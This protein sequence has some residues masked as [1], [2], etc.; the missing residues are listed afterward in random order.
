MW[1]ASWLQGLQA[2]SRRTRRDRGR[3]LKRHQRP[4][5]RIPMPRLLLERLEE[6]CLLSY[7]IT[8]LGT[9][10]GGDYSTAAGIND[11]GQVVGYSSAIGGYHAFLWDAV[12]GMQD[13]GTLGGSSSAQGI[14]DSGQVVG[15]GTYHAFLW[16]ATNGMQ[17]L[18]TLPAGRF[19]MAVG[20]NDS[21][22]VVGESAADPLYGPIHAFLWDAVNGMQD[23]GTLPGG[24]DSRAFSINNSGQV[25]GRSDTASGQSHACL[26]V[27]VS[28]AVTAPASTVHLT[29]SAPQAV[30]PAD[31]TFTA[32]DAGVHTFSDTGLGETTVVT[33]G[34]QTV[35]ATDTA[36]DTIT[37]SAAVTVNSSAPAP[38]GPLRANPD[39]A[40]VDRL[41][42]EFFRPR[43]NDPGLG[44]MQSWGLGW[45][46]GADPLP[47]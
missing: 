27:P 39:V 28:F 20:I 38:R 42:A 36:D 14:N 21:G 40:P 46:D 30:L 32:A 1:L 6:R 25:V 37:G 41:F 5:R 16:D 44:E 4:G 3:H 18:G 10:P 43:S 33:P 2:D 24:Y 9:L 23:L 7:Q 13:L 35:T 17:D 34:D 22:Q 12:N 8:D 45:L 15:G 31:Y 11:S 47:V 19:S 29:S 26:W